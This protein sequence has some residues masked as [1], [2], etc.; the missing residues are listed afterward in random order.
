[1][2]YLTLKT[3]FPLVSKWSPGKAFL[4]Q[5]KG[6]KSQY[7]TSPRQTMPYAVKIERSHALI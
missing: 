3:A 7:T 4:V 1:M 5:V 6:L 2:T